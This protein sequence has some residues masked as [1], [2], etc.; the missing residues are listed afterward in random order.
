MRF[1]KEPPYLR[2]TDVQTHLHIASVVGEGRQELVEEEAVGGVDLYK[3]VASSHRSL[4]GIRPELDVAL[5]FIECHLLRSGVTVVV[6]N[7]TAGNDVPAALLLGDSGLW[8]GLEGS[9]SGSLAT[10]MMELWSPGGGWRRTW[11]PI[12]LP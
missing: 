1:S 12:L 9:V 6:G 8:T 2:M 7:G 11:M 4:G 10:S 3:V 5:D